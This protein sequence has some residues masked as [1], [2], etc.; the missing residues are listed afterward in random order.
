MTYLPNQACATS[1]YAIIAPSSWTF[2]SAAPTDYHLIHRVIASTNTTSSLNNFKLPICVLDS[3][4]IAIDASGLDESQYT[5]TS[6][7]GSGNGREISKKRSVRIFVIS[8]V[9]FLWLKT[10][11][12][13]LFALDSRDE[14]LAGQASIESTVSRNA[15][16]T[17]ED[18]LEVHV[19]SQPQIED[20]DTDYRTTVPKKSV[21]VPSAE[22][23]IW[24]GLF[25]EDE[26]SNVPALQPTTDENI[27]AHISATSA[28]VK[29]QEKLHCG[30]WESIQSS[31][32]QK[33]S[34]RSECLN[35]P[36]P[37]FDSGTSSNYEYYHNVDNLATHT[38]ATPDNSFPQLNTSCA[39]SKDDNHNSVLTIQQHLL[40]QNTTKYAE[41]EPKRRAIKPKLKKIV[42]NARKLR[43]GFKRHISSLKKN[44]IAFMDDIEMLE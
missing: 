44:Y 29:G 30:L 4:R 34:N 23:N 26:E 6:P 5:V 28:T 42:A 11:H 15:S 19:L 27:T 20:I 16:E 38:H 7:S 22:T 39:H 14:G 32:V 36:V 2:R 1:N 37:L 40:E 8:A 33:H 24:N 21:D 18:V 31:M 41:Q 43:N 25:H 35:D 10:L 13:T 9:L 12:E 17:V 3:H